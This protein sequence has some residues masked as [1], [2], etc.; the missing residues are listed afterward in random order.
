MKE[1]RSTFLSFVKSE[2]KSGNRKTYAYHKFSKIIN[3]RIFAAERRLTF[4]CKRSPKQQAV[5]NA[6]L[7]FTKIIRKIPFRFFQKP[8]GNENVVVGKYGSEREKWNAYRSQR[9]QCEVKRQELDFWQNVRGVLSILRFLK[10]L[11]LHFLFY[12]KAFSLRVYLVQ[13]VWIA[14]V[15]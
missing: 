14:N 1:N 7:R 12:S 2:P 10:S 15:L 8:D 4:Q 6:W 11:F 5:N 9:A 13:R 3:F